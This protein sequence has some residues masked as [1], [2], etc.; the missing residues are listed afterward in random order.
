MVH[1]PTV[2]TAGLQ[3]ATVASKKVGKQTQSAQRAE[4][5]AWESLASS[6]NRGNS[7]C[8]ELNV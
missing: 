6:C 3:E 4:S 7:C 2:E 5:V 1:L 8:I